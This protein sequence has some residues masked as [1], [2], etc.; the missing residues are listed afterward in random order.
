MRCQWRSSL[1][2]LLIHEPWSHDRHSRIA[3]ITSGIATAKPLARQLKRPLSTTGKTVGFYPFARGLIRR[4]GGTGSASHLQAS[5]AHLSANGTLPLAPTAELTTEVPR[6]PAAFAMRF[7]TDVEATRLL[8]PLALRARRAG[9]DVPTD[10]LEDFF[11]EAL[12]AGVFF[13]GA[14]AAEA[15]FAGALAAEAF[16]AGALAAEAFFAGALAAEAFFAGALAAEAFFAG[17][18]AAEAFLAGALAAEAFFAGAL[19]AEAFFA[20]VLLVDLPGPRLR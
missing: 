8:L 7:A 17:A 11:A 10:A 19:A 20:G 4:N 9:R 1:V 12:T 2:M 15:F 14:L 3:L 13:A 18:L 5:S 6:R 16:L